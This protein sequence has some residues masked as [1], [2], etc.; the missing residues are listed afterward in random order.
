MERLSEQIRRGPPGVGARLGLVYPAVTRMT[1]DRVDASARGAAVGAMTS[2]WDLGILAAGLTAGG[3]G[4]RTAFSVAA[5]LAI[6]SL[7]VSTL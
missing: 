4:F 6:V 7:T 3:L 1:L 2:C 5:A